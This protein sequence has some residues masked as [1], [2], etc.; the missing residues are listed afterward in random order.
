GQK[1]DSIFMALQ[2]ITDGDVRFEYVRI[3]DA[4]K[5]GIFITT[6]PVN[7][8]LDSLYVGNSEFYDLGTGIAYGFILFSNWSSFGYVEIENVKIDTCVEFGKPLSD[9]GGHG[10]VATGKTVKISNISVKNSNGRYGGIFALADELSISEI[11]IENSREGF[12][13]STYLDLIA[14]DITVKNS[15]SSTVSFGKGGKNEVTNMKLI[16]CLSNETQNRML[17]VY[18]AGTFIRCQFIHDDD[19]KPV[20]PVYEYHANFNPLGLISHRP[21]NNVSYSDKATFIDCEFVNLIGDASKDTY[22]FSVW[23]D[24]Y[25][26]MWDASLSGNWD[27]IGDLF[28]QN[29]DLKDCSFTLR[30]GERVGIIAGWA[31]FLSGDSP[32]PPGEFLADNAKIVDNGSTIPLFWFYGANPVNNTF[33]FKPNNRYK[34]PGAADFVTLDSAAAINNLSRL[35]KGARITIEP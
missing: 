33:R 14:S 19:M 10:I 5:Y 27:K 22:I 35:D 30:Q 3:A 12:Y 34:A 26:Y 8:L 24:V 16:N 15:G 28:T 4:P 11:T 21:Y 18:G 31:Y 9:M 6:Y 13:I 25:S 32:K 2:G 1:A 7:V 29:I 23:S 17:K 20:E